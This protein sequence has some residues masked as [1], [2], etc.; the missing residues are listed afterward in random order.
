M[1]R[2]ERFHALMD[3]NLTAPNM[4]AR[5]FARGMKQPGQAVVAALLLDY[6]DLTRPKGKQ[7]STYAYALVAVLPI[8]DYRLF[9]AIANRRIAEMGHTPHAELAATLDLLALPSAALVYRD[10]AVLDGIER[11][12]DGTDLVEPLTQATTASLIPADSET[13]QQDTDWRSAIDATRK[14][15]GFDVPQPPEFSIDPT[16]RE[17]A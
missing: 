15:I 8:K 11:V 5:G 9:E 14:E 16:W 4:V 7:S 13:V 3:T 1:T 17:T 6:T 10:D 2:N 12:L